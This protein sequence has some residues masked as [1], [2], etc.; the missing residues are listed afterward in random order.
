MRSVSGKRHL[1]LSKGETGVFMGGTI[2]FGYSNI[3]KKWTINKEEASI[4]KQMFSLYAQ[5][6]SI[7]DIKGNLDS[8]GIKPRRSKLWNIHTILKM[9]KNTTYVGFARVSI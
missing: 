4:V 6:T 9:L 3:D 7:Q 8:Q 1:S 2:A 5:G